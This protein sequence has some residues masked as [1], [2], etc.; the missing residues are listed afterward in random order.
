MTDE[1]LK[2]L[3]D[4]ISLWDGS[5]H[6]Y[7]CGKDKLKEDITEWFK[8]VTN[9]E[10]CPNEKVC[11]FKPLGFIVGGNPVKEPRETKFYEPEYDSWDDFVR[12]WNGEEPKKPNGLTEDDELIR[13]MAIVISRVQKLGGDNEG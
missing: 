9:Q 2:E 12:R 3:Y 6:K 11:P 10:G 13:A 7:F 5:P 4:I 1:L 8:R